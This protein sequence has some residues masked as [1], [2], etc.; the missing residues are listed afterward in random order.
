MLQLNAYLS[1]NGTCADAMHFYERALGG[2]IEALMKYGETPMCDQMPP[3]CS[4]LVMHARLAVNGGVLL[5]GDALPGQPFNGIKGISM[6]LT[7]PT[8]E[9]AAEVFAALSDGGQVTMPLQ[10][11]FWAEAAGMLVDR[12]GTPWIV[13]GAL[14]EAKDETATAPR[15]A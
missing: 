15:L 9:A 3:G 6:T 12:F 1:F 4:E 10:K 11:T 14:I 2:K 7:Y 5:A 13:N 8:P